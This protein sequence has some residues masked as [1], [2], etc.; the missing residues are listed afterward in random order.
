MDPS[1]I[2]GGRG[3]A[4]LGNGHKLGLQA[5]AEMLGGA[6]FAPQFMNWFQ[7]MDFPI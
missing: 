5:N 2:W 3:L 7:A 6:A 1:A 4:G